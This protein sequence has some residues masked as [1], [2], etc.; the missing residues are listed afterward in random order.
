MS[1]ANRNPTFGGNVVSSSSS[2]CL[3]GHCEPEDKDIIL[4]RNAGFRLASDAASYP[5]VMTPLSKDSY[6]NKYR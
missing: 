2:K 6:K 1:L 3:R 4:P 5:G